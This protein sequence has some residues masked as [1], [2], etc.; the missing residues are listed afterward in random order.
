MMTRKLLLGDDFDDHA[1]EVEAKGW[2]AAHLKIDGILVPV[3]FYDPTRLAQEIRDALVEP[4]VFHEQHVIVVQRL[5]RQAMEEAVERLE[6][7]LVVRV[8]NE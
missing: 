5:T 1:W 2:F 8:V 3:T 4:G 6:A 7:S